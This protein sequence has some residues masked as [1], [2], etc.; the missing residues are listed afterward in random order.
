MCKLQITIKLIID[1]DNRYRFDTITV[2]PQ[3]TQFTL[4][5]RHAH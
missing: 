1:I 4:D 3:P 2:A 5:D